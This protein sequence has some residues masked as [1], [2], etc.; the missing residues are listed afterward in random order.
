MSPAQVRCYTSSLPVHAQDVHHFEEL[1]HPNT[2]ITTGLL[3]N[4]PVTTSLTARC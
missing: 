1:P 3:N 2:P 4:L